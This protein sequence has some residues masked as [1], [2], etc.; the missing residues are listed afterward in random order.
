MARIHSAKIK[1]TS[2]SS[3]Q[4]ETKKRNEKVT[5]TTQN[6]KQ[7]SAKTKGKANVSVEPS[8]GIDKF[9][10]EIL[11]LGGDEEDYELLKDLDS[12][13]EAGIEHKSNED[14]SVETALGLF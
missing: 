6:A 1:A 9:R 13:A 10:E 5:E 7:K 8:Q 4:D 14:V 2:S 11:A 12:E 3:R